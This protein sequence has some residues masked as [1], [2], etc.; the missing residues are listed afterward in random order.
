MGFKAIAHDLFT[1]MDADNSGLIEYDELIAS[2]QRA[3]PKV[4]LCPPQCCI[5]LPL[6]RDCAVTVP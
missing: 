4:R 1:E 3:V 6:C 2:L 5:V